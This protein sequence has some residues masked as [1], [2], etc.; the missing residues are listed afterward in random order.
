M[1]AA[2]LHPEARLPELGRLWM[3]DAEFRCIYD[4]FQ[5]DNLRR[6][7]RVWMLDQFA[8]LVPDLAGDTAECGVWTGLGSYVICR[9]SLGT[10]KVH[11][12]FDSFA[13]LSVPAPIDGQHWT[14][15]ALA[16]PLE[17][18]QANLAEFDFVR[19]HKGWIPETF[20]EIEGPFALVHLDLDLYEPTRDSLEFFYPKMSQIGRAHV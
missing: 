19:L 13:G 11:H 7:D 4:R 14:P 3:H 18:A 16:A 1:I 17:L 2:K 9:R 15:G 20:G 8:R 5:A 10:G 12:G 6:M